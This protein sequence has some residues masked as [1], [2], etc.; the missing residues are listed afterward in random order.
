MQEERQLGLLNRRSDLFI[1]NDVLL[2]TQLTILQRIAPAP[3]K[4]SASPAVFRR[5]K[6]CSP[7]VVEPQLTHL[8]TLV[9][10]KFTTNFGLHSSPTTSQLQ[11]R[12]W[13]HSSTMRG[14][15]KFS[16]LKGTCTKQGPC[17]VTRVY[18][19]RIGDLQASRGCQVDA[20]I[21]SNSIRLS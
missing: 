7:T 8:V 10:R 20:T 11:L 6:C 15:A 5:R 1:I 16:N 4:R 13:T 18:P 21:M 14:P 3:S 2:Y 19:K 17:D 9:A 12:V